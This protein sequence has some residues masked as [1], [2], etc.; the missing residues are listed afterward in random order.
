MPPPIRYPLPTLVVLVLLAL[1]A[2]RGERMTRS[3]RASLAARWS[4]AVEG[5]PIPS[6]TRPQV[7]AGPVVR[8]ALLLHDDVAASSR[9]GGPPS[10]TI[11]VRMFTDIYD[12]WPLDG[13]PHFYRVGN[14]S[15]IGWVKADDLLPWDTRL[16]VRG[17]DPTDPSVRST[18]PVLAWTADAVEVATWDESEPWTRV[19]QHTQ[20][21]L[22]RLRPDD[23]GVWLSREEL[24]GLLRRVE[25]KATE[26]PEATR[27]R[28]LLGRVAEARP[29]TAADI[30]AARAVLPTLAFATRS[31]A[32]DRVG[33]A[34][35][36][37]NE[38]WEP[39]A[40]WGGFSFRFVPLSS[41]P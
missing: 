34:L 24:L 10:D 1:A 31:T 17:P 14:R 22:G 36:R 37:V 8:K 4:R 7:V 18:R 40:S 20:I 6:S 3:V 11:R 26:P 23:W 27:L 2:W 29:M 15:P 9:P 16:V 32:P 19:R 38:S 13:P 30:A 39:E 5:P 28:A 12:V 41:L 33:E 35:A 25:G 21:P